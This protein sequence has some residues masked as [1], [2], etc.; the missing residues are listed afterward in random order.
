MSQYSSAAKC[1]CLPP[2]FKTGPCPNTALPR[3][4][5]VFLRLLK[6]VPLLKLSRALAH[7]PLDR[8]TKM[9]V[10]FNERHDHFLG[11]GADTCGDRTRCLSLC[12]QRK[13][14]SG[15]ADPKSTGG[16]IKIGWLSHFVITCLA[17]PTPSERIVENQMGYSAAIQVITPNQQSRW[18]LSY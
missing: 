1:Y 13:A 12:H 11:G 3:I 2:S 5:T 10:S 6:Q 15:S 7:D 8:F 16:Q 4:A 17:P 18:E 9:V 14:L